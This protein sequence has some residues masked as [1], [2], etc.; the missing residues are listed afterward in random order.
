MEF[1]WSGVAGS[2]PA[3]THVDSRG[4]STLATRDWDMT[5]RKIYRLQQEYAL[6]IYF[7]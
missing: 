2:T 1:T 4:L 7:I 5:V 3:L 6:R